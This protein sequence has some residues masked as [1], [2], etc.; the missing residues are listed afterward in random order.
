MINLQKLDSPVL[1]QGD[2]TTAYRDPAILHHDNVF[3]LFA[4]L[5]EIEADGRIYAYTV[6]STSVDLLQWSA[7]KKLTPK[8]Q[9]LNYSSPGNV[10]RF[11]DE[12]I[13][14]LQTYPRPGY[15]IEQIPRYGDETSRLFVMRSADLI[16]WSAPELLKVKGPEVAVGAMER[17]IDP[18]L[19][20]DKDK[21]GLWWCF[22]KQNGVSMSSSEDLETWRYHG[23]TPSGENVCVLVEDDEYIL[24]HSPRNGIGIKRSVDLK[25][26]V[27]WGDLITLGQGSWPWARGRITAG[28]VV[29]LKHL[30]GVGKYL[31]LFHGS[32]PHDEQVNFDNNASIGLAWSDDL[33]NWSWPGER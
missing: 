15:T 31:M 4:T 8:D 19:L 5:I 26:W 28:A 20:E 10:I 27:D 23:H 12:W 2:E 9:A 17:M 24:F 30:P 29:N 25:H 7:P 11:N 6:Q 32:G 14:C 22:Y 3:Y 21:A 18:Y 33:I 16:T 13:L 1:L